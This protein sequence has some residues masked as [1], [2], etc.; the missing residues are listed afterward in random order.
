MQPKSKPKILF[1]TQQ[2]ARKP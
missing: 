2:P 1:K